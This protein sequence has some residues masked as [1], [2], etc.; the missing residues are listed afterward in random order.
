MFVFGSKLTMGFVFL[1]GSSPVFPGQLSF[2]QANGVL[3]VSSINSSMNSD[4]YGRETTVPFQYGPPNLFHPDSKKPEGT[5]SPTSA[6][7]ERG[8]VAAAAAAHE[9]HPGRSG[10]KGS[11]GAAE[12][13]N[14]KMYIDHRYG[15]YAVVAPH[16]SAT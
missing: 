6:L 7:R 4:A 15:K 9:S 12:S 11:V 13:V 5:R 3:S 14:I 1:V 2:L 16:S 10:T 8:V